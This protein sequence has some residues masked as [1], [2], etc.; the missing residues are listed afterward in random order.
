MKVPSVAQVSERCSGC[1]VCKVFC[2]SGALDLIEEK[3]FP[4]LK[5]MQV[6]PALCTGC[7]NC[8]TRGPNGARI[9]GCPWDAIR[10]IPC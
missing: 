3:D 4:P 1:G 5:K 7:G 6:D 2:T 10:L 8:L 9:L